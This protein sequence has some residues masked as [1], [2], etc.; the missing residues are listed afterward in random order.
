[1]S[2]WSQ[3]RRSTG[4][5]I[6]PVAP[7]RMIR[8]SFAECCSRIRSQSCGS[9]P[10]SSRLIRGPGLP[11][12]RRGEGGVTSGVRRF[13]VSGSHRYR[14][15]RYPRGNVIPPSSHARG[16]VDIDREGTMGKGRG[17]VHRGGDRLRVAWGWRTQTSAGGS[18]SVL[19]RAGIPR[20]AADEC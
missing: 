3:K 9:A 18:A 11:N 10:L 20:A 1:M 5:G 7:C 14:R 17:P 8:G 6:P 15:G 16:A 4:S 12:P 13:V 2:V 19:L